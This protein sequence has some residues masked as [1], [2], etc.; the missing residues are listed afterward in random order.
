MNTM[1]STNTQNV[2]E[3]HVIFGTGPMGASIMEALLQRGKRVRMVNR[4]G[5]PSA[6]TGQPNGVEFKQANLMDAASTSAAAQG[7]THIY[8]AAQPEYH[9]WAEKFPPI[10][11]NILD[12]AAAHGAKLIAVENLY[13][14]GDTNGRPMTEE[15]P[16]K[17]VSK[18]G[19]VR[20]RMAQELIDAHKSGKAQTA[21]VRGADF[22]GPGYLIM[23]D[24]IF[25]PAVAGKQASGMGKIDLPHTF[26]YTK[27]FG[28]ALV[29]VGET[30][31]AM[32]QAWHTPSAIITQRHLITLAFQAAGTAPKIG[33]INKL[34]MQF[35]GLFVPGARETVEMMYEFEKPFIMDSTKF[36]RA[37]NVKSTPHADAMRETVAW[38]KANPKQK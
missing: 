18:K 20:A 28:K 30:D 24:Q 10:Q 26:T 35:A 31:S 27:D 32:G 3:L 9:E 2:N 7:A 33:S 11:R 29:T 36:E 23:G 34:M 6:V 12:A 21:A 19:E 22:Y 5:K 17:P 8:Q 14:Y 37:F 25:Y 13:M 1:N 16:F 4:S 15:T 38:F